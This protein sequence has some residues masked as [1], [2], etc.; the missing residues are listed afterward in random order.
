MAAVSTSHAQSTE[1]GHTSLVGH[2][3]IVILESLIDEAIHL[4]LRQ[5]RVGREDQLRKGGENV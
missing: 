5:G 1:W 2:T 3:L 4:A